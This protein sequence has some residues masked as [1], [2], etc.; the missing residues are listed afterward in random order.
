MGRPSASDTGVAVVAE[1]PEAAGVADSRSGCVAASHARAAIGPTDAS[2][3]LGYSILE[4]VQALV[5]ARR[6]LDDLLMGLVR[7]SWDLGANRCRLASILGVSR[8][9]LYRHFGR[10]SQGPP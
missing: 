1:L 6:V 7:Q 3:P 2:A 10:G 4:Q 9:G 8:A 5:A